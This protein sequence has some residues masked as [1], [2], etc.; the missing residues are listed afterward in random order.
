MSDSLLSGRDSGHDDSTTAS[1]SSILY[2]GSQF[3]LLIEKAP[4]LSRHNMSNGV[5]LIIFRASKGSLDN[6][7]GQPPRF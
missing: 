4:N 1:G 2:S 3:A 7:V 6:K 5:L